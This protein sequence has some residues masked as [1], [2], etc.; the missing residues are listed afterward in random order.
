MESPVPDLHYYQMVA[1]SKGISKEDLQGELIDL[2]KENK[3]YIGSM[4]ILIERIE[5]ESL[6]KV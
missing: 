6:E 2:I 1:K 5:N 4:Q 3:S